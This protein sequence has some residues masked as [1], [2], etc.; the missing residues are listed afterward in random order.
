MKP[1]ADLLLEHQKTPRRY[2]THPA[3]AELFSEE[4]ERLLAAYRGAELCQIQVN[5][6]A[7]RTGPEPLHVEWTNAQA[8]KV[9]VQ[10]LIIEGKADWSNL[11][12]DFQ[13]EM[14]E[15]LKSFYSKIQAATLVLDGFIVIVSPDAIVDLENMYRRFGR[16][17]QEYSLLR[18]ISFPEQS[19]Q[20]AL[21]RWKSD[22]VW[23]VVLAYDD[24]DTY[25]L[26]EN[27]AIFEKNQPMETFDEWMARI[28]ATNGSPV[29]PGTYEDSIIKDWVEQ[30]QYPASGSLSAHADG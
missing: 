27:D 28:L 17:C 9:E 2:W 29:I 13:M 10:H 25:E 7:R 16:P 22:G 8:R 21:R 3:Y 5:P 23:R 11:E 20:L 26:Q 24:V 30:I 19:A 14:P 1:A 4:R 12:N 6:K 18:F 15:C